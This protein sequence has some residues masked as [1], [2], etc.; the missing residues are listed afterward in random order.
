MSKIGQMLID[1]QI[2]NADS[3]VNLK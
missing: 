3:A 1:L 2:F